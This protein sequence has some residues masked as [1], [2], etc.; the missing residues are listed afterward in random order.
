MF[1]WL[2]L[3]CNQPEKCKA[4]NFSQELTANWLLKTADKLLKNAIL[5]EWIKE[6]FWKPVQTFIWEYSFKWY[7]AIQ[8]AAGGHLQWHW[9]GI[10]WSIFGALPPSKH[11]PTSKYTLASMSSRK[12]KQEELKRRSCHRLR[13]AVCF[14][15]D[16]VYNHKT[17]VTCF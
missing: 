6:L 13:N 16:L 4:N 2:F 10:M 7:A 17:T 9:L 1:K 11:I 5:S 14:L 15:K 8:A 12:Q 3:A